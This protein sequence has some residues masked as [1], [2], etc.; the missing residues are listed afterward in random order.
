[1]KY[2]FFF[3][4]NPLDNR[5]DD[6]R[7][8]IDRWSSEVLAQHPENADILVV[9]GGDGTLLEAIHELQ[10]FGKPFFGIGRGTK[11]Y[12]LNEIKSPNDIP[13]GL[14]EF[15]AHP[16]ELTHYMG[17]YFMAARGAILANDLIF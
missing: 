14:S 16:R 12:L 11:N 8:W 5:A 7:G 13:R 3:P 2:H 17:L 10:R 4:R 1:M 15:A 6:V 9:A